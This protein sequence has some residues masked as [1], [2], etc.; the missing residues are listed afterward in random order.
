[1]TTG[2]AASETGA[3]AGRGAIIATSGDL[4]FGLR[5]LLRIEPRF[6]T[7]FAAVGLP[8]L[9][10]RPDRFEALAAIV[11]GQQ[12]STA[13]AAAIAGRLAA[14]G[15]TGAA[16]YRMADP[17]RLGACGLSRAKIACL[18]AIAAD[19]PDFT[20]LR[21]ADDATVI[22]RLVALPGIGQWSAELYALT[23]LGRPDVLPAGD[24][25]LREAARLLFDLPARPDPAALRAMGAAW[26]PWRAVA[27]RLL[28]AYYREIRGREGVR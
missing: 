11:V 19:P 1:M 18:T 14:A 4:E 21:E 16:A 15:L 10:L 9:R 25:A 28:W 12:I 6:A 24:V 3:T 27:A 22:A 17:A 26:A 5:E 20:S 8:P 7:A 2:R 13:A 23:A